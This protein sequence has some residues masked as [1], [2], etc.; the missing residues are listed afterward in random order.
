METW[1]LPSKVHK[2]IYKRKKHESLGLLSDITAIN[3]GGV[4]AQ[5]DESYLRY[6]GYFRIQ[7]LMEWG[8]YREAL[9][10][11]CLE[12]ELYP[13]NNEVLFVK[14]NIKQKIRNLPQSN[15]TKKSTPNTKSLW[16]K[17]A[18]MRELKAIIERDLLLPFSEPD[19]YKKYNLQI[20]N[21]FLLYGPP[22]CGKTLISQQIAK[23]L[24][25]NYIEVVP[26]TTGSIYV[27][28]TQINI[29][30]VFNDAKNKRPSLIFIDEFDAFAPDRNKGDLSHSFQSE[31][32]EMLVQL[33]NAFDNGILVIAAT[34]Y[35]NKIDPA[36]LRP[37]R[38]DKKIFVGPPDFEARIETFK[39]YLENTP[40]SIRNWD[41]LVEETEFYTFAEIKFIVD[42][43]KRKAFEQSKPVDLNF[44]MKAVI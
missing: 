34:N 24:K 32:N 26:S 7:L 30:E 9:A 6:V 23:I 8:Y 28:G 38:I 11:A 5:T 44:L 31:V 42:E 21:G 18:G 15:L 37:G 41:F 40:Y 3:T 4:F 27:H 16:G 1:T 33:N 43:S 39:L 22:G 10:W 19:E 29:K 36:I 14:E 25:F 12:C 20:P 35:I 17:I 2:L 13:D